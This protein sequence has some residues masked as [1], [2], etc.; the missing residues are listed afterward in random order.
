MSTFAI[1]TLC[2]FG[3]AAATVWLFTNSLWSILALVVVEAVLLA[4]DYWLS[5]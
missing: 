2:V 1:L 4:L 3:I 5:G